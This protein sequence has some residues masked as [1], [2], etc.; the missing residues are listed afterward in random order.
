LLLAVEKKHLKIAHLLLDKGADTN[1]VTI[2]ENSALHM[3]AVMG[4]L[5][6]VK[7]MVKKGGD[8]HL[9]NRDRETP[10]D[11]AIKYERKAVI[12]YLTKMEAKK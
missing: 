8:V 1:A 12:K 2:G 6:V 3:A 4:Y 5:D 10:L 9:L 7:H 11:R